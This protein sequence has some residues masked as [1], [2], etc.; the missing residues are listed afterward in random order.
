MLLLLSLPA[1]EDGGWCQESL[2]EMLLVPGSASG[3]GVQRQWE[4]H[5]WYFVSCL[6]CHGL[7]VLLV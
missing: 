3:V 7:M 2:L 4:G 5:L 1:C 6:Q